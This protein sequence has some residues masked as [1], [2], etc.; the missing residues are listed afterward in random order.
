[1]A[2]LRENIINELS[3]KRRSISEVL[4]RI[5]LLKWEL[6]NS[7]EGV[8]DF[9]EDEE[10]N[11]LLESPN[12]TSYTDLKKVLGGIR[13]VV[14]NY[15]DLIKLIDNSIHQYVQVEA[16][17]TKKDTLAE[18][19]TVAEACQML[20][21]SKPTFYSMVGKGLIETRKV[22]ERRTLVNLH[23]L[24]EGIETGAVGRYVH[25]QKNGR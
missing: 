20:H 9:N 4:Q 22:G 19:G 25:T 16:E 23:R 2:T 7:P 15:D 3:D 8:L 10:Y 13:L 21:V 5:E 18:W 17:R 1:M 11:S 24:R 6:E 14:F 12:S